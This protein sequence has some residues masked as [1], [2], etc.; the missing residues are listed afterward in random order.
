ML[1]KA[2]PHL[3]SE[4]A[5][6]RGMNPPPS[7]ADCSMATSNLELERKPLYISII[8]IQY[9]APSGKEAKPCVVYVVGGVTKTGGR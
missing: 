9:A 8:S 2:K 3:L 5:L 6:L 1:K 4:G 7:S